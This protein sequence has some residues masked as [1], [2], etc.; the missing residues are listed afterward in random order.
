MNAFKQKFLGPLAP[1]AFLAL[2]GLSVFSVN[3]LVLTLVYW[4][5]VQVVE[6]F[7]WLFPIGLRMDV[8]AL[9]L[10]LPIPSALLLLLPNIK[11]RANRFALAALL[12]AIGL[13][14]VFMEAASL[15]FVQQFDSRPNRIFVDYLRYPAEVLGTIWKIHKPEILVTLA[16]LIITGR[17]I[18]RTTHRA[19]E[20]HQPWSW[21]KRLAVLPLV[22][23]L[24]VAGARSSF[25][26]RPANISTAAFSTDHLVNELALNSAYTVGYAVYRRRN[27]A[28][29][30]QL[31]GAMPLDEAAARVQRQSLLPAK[32]FTNGAYPTLHTAVSTHPQPR[33]YNLVIFLQ[34]SLGAEYV[35]TLGGLPLTPNIDALSKEGLLFTNLYSTGTRT[36]RGIEAMVTGFFPSPSASVL[37]LGHSQTGFFTVAELLRRAGYATEFIYG[38]ASHFDNMAG[39]MLG[40]GFQQ[41]IDERDFEHPAFQGTWGVSDEDLVRRANDTFVAHG[42]QPFFALML[43]TSN[44]EPFE[45]PAGRFELYEQPPNTV[46]NAI[47]YADYAIGE[48]FRLA[49]KE[50]YFQNTVFIVVADHNTRVY[51]VDLVP[52]N[53]FHIP[54][55]II[56][57]DVKPQRYNKVASQ[58]DLL[59]T[60]LDLIGMNT[61]H[62]MMGHNIFTLPPDYPGHALM[63][64]NNE[65]AYMLG[66][67]VVIHEPYKPAKQFRYREGRLLPETL[68]PELERDALTD[69]VLP[70]LLYNER[71]YALPTGSGPGHTVQLAR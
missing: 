58:V 54:A 42:D 16:L 15:P 21:T 70:Y 44:H 55:L 53:K 63:Q 59:P 22:L 27:E 14:M 68:D 10:L 67:Q 7:W 56:G 71:R 28:D 36:V 41:V 18:W 38:G 39:F 50:K 24:L 52:I 69:V 57:P 26:V 64:Y 32:S 3:R 37:K 5:R 62:P 4:D 25:G 61:E 45:Y 19:L 29:A 30:V 13:F 17:W 20:Q 47:K 9:S 34:E 65:H 8:I 31:Y 11:H 48:F 35:G 23:V 6:H 12:T 66:D 43:S 51:G 49:K 60:L 46:N 1:V 2:L 33:P 40:N